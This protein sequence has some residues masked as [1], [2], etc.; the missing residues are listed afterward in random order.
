[1]GLPNIFH[2][3]LINEKSIKYDNITIFLTQMIN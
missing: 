3:E 1:M 2:R